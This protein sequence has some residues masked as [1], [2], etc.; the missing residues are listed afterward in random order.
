MTLEEIRGK[1]KN[2]DYRLSGHAVK[3]MIEKLIDRSEVEEAILLGEV[4]EQY[5]DDKYSPSYLVYGRTSRGR[6]LHV[7]VSL[8]PT[9]VVIT[10]Y[11]PDPGKWVDYRT[12]K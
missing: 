2:G 9:V 4:I 10:T 5:P 8:P 1:V 12:R 6:N 7:Q 3:R 11:E